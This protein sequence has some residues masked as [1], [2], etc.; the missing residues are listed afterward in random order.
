MLGAMHRIRTRKWDACGA[1]TVHGIFLN[2]CSDVRQIT[3]RMDEQAAAGFL[4]KGFPNR[5]TDNNDQRN[6][7]H[8]LRRTK[9]D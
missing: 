3:Q 8:Q 9:R 1:A 5:P 2:G 7:G 6:A 4:H